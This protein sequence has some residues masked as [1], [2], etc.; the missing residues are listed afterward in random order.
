MTR[1]AFVTF[2]LGVGLAGCGGGE[3]PGQYF[4]LK[5]NGTENLCTGGGT[6]YSETLEY[7]VIVDGNDLQ[8]AIEEDIFATGTIEGCS[9]SYASIVWSDYRDDKEIKWQILGSADANLGGASGC[10]TD[11]DWQGEETFIIVT[12]EH[13][14][15][16]PGCTYSLGLTGK[17]LREVGGEEADDSNPVE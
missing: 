7:R 9:L 6:S 16:Q 1:T 8:L 17:F 4:D 11:G 15:V 10:V 2:T 3:L 13:D 5:A 14:E 12:S